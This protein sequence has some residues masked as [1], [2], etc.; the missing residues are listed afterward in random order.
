MQAHESDP[1]YRPPPDCAEPLSPIL[2]FYWGREIFPGKRLG[3]LRT[4]LLGIPATIVAIAGWVCGALLASWLIGLL[5][6]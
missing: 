3:V 6:D 1:A 5:G 4:C 2:G